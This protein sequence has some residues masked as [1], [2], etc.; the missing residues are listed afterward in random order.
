MSCNFAGFLGDRYPLCTG[1]PS[2]GF[3]K[4]GAR[5]K[6]TGLVSTEGPE[7]EKDS[8]CRRLTLA[9]TGDLYAALCKKNNGV[10]TFPSE[11]LL[12]AEII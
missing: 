6:Y 3:L 9:T 4:Q 1:L 12:V 2:R 5:Y 8:N 7:C 10:C 11:V